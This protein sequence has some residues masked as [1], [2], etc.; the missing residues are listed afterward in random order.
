MSDEKTL[1]VN[2]KNA[3]VPMT[4]RFEKGVYDVID[5]I[6]KR[7]KVSKADIVRYVVDSKLEKYL[8]CIRY[9]DEQQGQTIHQNII[10]IGN[11]LVS[12][13]D[14]MN[15]IGVNY[16]Q[17]VKIKNIERKLAEN[18]D[19]ATRSLKYGSSVPKSSY[20]EKKRLEA[21]K[22]KIESSSSEL[23]RDEL[24]ELMKKMEKVVQEV[25]DMLCTL[26]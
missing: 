19:A 15:R 1:D 12:I 13:R 22:E 21:E 3:L 11:V 8:G 10:T 6:A 20:D 23:K 4:V 18:K 17:E 2:D 16:N 24:Q 25:G 5:D 7:N 14:E 26:E 9:I